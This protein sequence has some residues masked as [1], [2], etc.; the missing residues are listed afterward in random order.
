MGDVFF[1]SVQ[2]ALLLV[3]FIGIPLLLVSFVI[4][5]CL[6]APARH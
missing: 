5:E 2:F 4:D 6:L 1:A 3:G